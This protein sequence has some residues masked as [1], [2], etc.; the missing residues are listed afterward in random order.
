MLLIVPQFLSPKIAP[1]NPSNY[2]LVGGLPGIC[3]ASKDGPP[4]P[5]TVPLVNGP[6]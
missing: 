3:M 6:P 4:R 5:S 1:D 2:C